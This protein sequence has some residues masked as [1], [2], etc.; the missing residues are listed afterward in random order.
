MQNNSCSRTISGVVE[1]KYS[2]N[3]N[4]SQKLQQRQLKTSVLEK[5]FDF[6]RIT[7]Y[8]L[9]EAASNS[10]QSRPTCDFN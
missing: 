7:S 4:S 1:N 10:D 8:K 6:L 2:R 3:Q 5:R 9:F